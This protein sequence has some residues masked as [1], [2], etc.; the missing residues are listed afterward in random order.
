MNITR[1]FTIFEY[2]YL[3]YFIILT[4]DKHIVPQNKTEVTYS[5]HLGIRT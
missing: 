1:R 2:Y 5:R 3:D 4:T